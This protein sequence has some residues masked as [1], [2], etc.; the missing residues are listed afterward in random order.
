[1]S[2]NKEQIRY[3]IKRDEEIYVDIHMDI[4]WFAQFRIQGRDIS[5]NEHLKQ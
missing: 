4:F 3:N 2:T 5:Q 1:M